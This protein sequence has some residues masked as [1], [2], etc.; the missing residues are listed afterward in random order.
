MDISRDLASGGPSWEGLRPLK[1]DQ[2][3]IYNRR[4]TILNFDSDED[5]ADERKTG[6]AF[7]S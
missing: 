2:S 1:D 5:S 6:V 4:K 3:V 7:K